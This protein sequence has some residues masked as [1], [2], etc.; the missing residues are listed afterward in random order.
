MDGALLGADDDGADAADGLAPA[1]F[2]VA[3]N[4]GAILSDLDDGFG[5][6][7]VHELGAG[8]LALNFFDDRDRRLGRGRSS[9]CQQAKTQQAK[10]N[11]NRKF[12]F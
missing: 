5:R 11:N 3:E 4:D 1:G 8:N 2:H 9:Q 6:H 10:T 12:H 7:I